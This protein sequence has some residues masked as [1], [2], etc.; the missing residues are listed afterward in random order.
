MGLLLRH[1]EIVGLLTTDETIQCVRA[2]F[3][4]QARGQVQVPSRITI[5]SSSGYG[6][7][8][9]MPAI[10]NGS[11]V[12]G[13]KAM[14]STPGVGVRYMVVLY[15]LKT[16]ALLAQLD[17]AWITAHRT[18]AVAAV[19][20]DEL[21][22]ADIR[23]TGLVGSGEQASSLLTAVSRVR[24]LHRV[25]VFSPNPEH[26][27]RFAAAMSQ[28]LGLEIIPVE[29]AKEA[30]ADCDLVLSAYRAGTEPVLSAEWLTNGAHVNAISAV[31]PEAREL[32]VEVWKKSA[33]VAVDDRTHVFESGDGKSAL[34][35][36][37][38]KTDETIELWELVGK[39]KP[40][41]Q[42]EHQITLFKSVGTALQD[43]S[44]AAAIYKRAEE[45]G[46]GLK[47]EDFPHVR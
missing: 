31:R 6:W 19:A 23:C 45:K 39:N 1:E 47:I 16:G 43:L 9:V 15:E 27:H 11:A 36:G 4:E 44:L 7:L 5:D 38:V 30:V 20:T 35:S 22:R 33:I 3:L 21:A 28:D 37:S 17:A 12:M 32:E 34:S 41:R 10:L 40:G 26:R 13:F 46:L 24:K 2:G 29:S 42:N 25:K 14:H 18:A 8:R